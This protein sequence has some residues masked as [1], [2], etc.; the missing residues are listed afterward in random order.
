MRFDPA[1]WPLFSSRNADAALTDRSN[2]RRP[3]A[4]WVKRLTNLKGGEQGGGSGKKSGNPLS[5]GKSKKGSSTAN[6]GV[7]NN[8][9]P[10]SGFVP[11]HTPRSSTDGFATPASRPQNDDGSII[12]EAPQEGDLHA[13]NRSAAPTVATHAGTVHSDAGHSKAFT[14]TTGAGALSSIDGRGGQGSTFSSPNQSERSLT[15]TLTTIQST[16][17][18]N[19]LQQTGTSGNLNHSSLPNGQPFTHQYPVSPAPSGMG[20][21]SAIP[22][23]LTDGQHNSGNV[24][25]DDASI[26]TLASSSKRRRRSMDTDASVR[27]LAPNSVWGGSRES[28]PLSVLSGTADG[29]ASTTGLYAASQSRP[30]IGGLASA[31]RASVYSSQGVSA[32]ALASERNSY[33]AGPSRKDLSD[34]KSLRSITNL[35]ARSQYDAKSINDARSMNADARSLRGYEG[36]IRSGALGHG[37]NDSIPGSIGS[38]LASPGLRLASGAGNSGAL[39]RRSSDWREMAEGSEDETGKAMEE[40]EDSKDH[41]AEPKA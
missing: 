25:T 28:L 13:S 21:P 15:T 17:P 6:A 30:S 36:S 11:R 34:A 24:L 26:V 2:K 39:S 19:A 1:S 16:S 18:A 4:A 9:Y 32:P 20:V 29:A 33:Y 7:K 31:E 14:N 41:G 12:S 8:P 10:E 3:F 5:T 22:R 37:R 23:H 35:D 27:A 38:P 40:I